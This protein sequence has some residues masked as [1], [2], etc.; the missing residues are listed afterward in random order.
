MAWRC[1]FFAK[2]EP[3][4]WTSPAI[5]SILL[6][7]CANSLAEGWIQRIAKAEHAPLPTWQGI[8][9]AVGTRT[10]IAGRHASPSRF[11]GVSPYRARISASSK[12]PSVGSPER[13]KAI[14]PTT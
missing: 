13:E 11:S 7:M 8:P 4:S 6:L 5:A 1:S 9:E 3:P 12:S 14:V 10:L 2:C